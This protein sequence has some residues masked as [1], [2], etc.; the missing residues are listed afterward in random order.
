MTQDTIKQRLQAARALID[1]PDKWTQGALQR[2]ASG[3][4]GLFA[5]GHQVVS[6]CASGAICDACESEDW[7]VNDDWNEVNGHLR[8]SI[9]RHG[10]NVYGITHWNDAPER[11]HAQVMLAFSRAIEDADANQ[12]RE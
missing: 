4:S 2:D 10:G 5:I 9:N 12:T 11:T 1:Q 7:D 6:R 3:R 8:R